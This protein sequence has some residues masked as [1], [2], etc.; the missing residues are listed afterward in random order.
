MAIKNG[1]KTLLRYRIK[2]MRPVIINAAISIRMTLSNVYGFSEKKLSKSRDVFC[3]DI[4]EAF[5]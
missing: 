4:I 1:T 2:S 5:G 3:F